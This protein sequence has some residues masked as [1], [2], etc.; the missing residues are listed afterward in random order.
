MAVAQVAVAGCMSSTG[1][2]QRQSTGIEDRRHAWRLVYNWLVTYI[3][4]HVHLT[5]TGYIYVIGD[6]DIGYW[7][8]ATKSHAYL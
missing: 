5:I 6:M 8:L 3:S 4:R 2:A 7:L 1:C